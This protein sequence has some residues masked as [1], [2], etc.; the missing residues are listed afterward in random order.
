MTSDRKNLILE[1]LQELGFRPDLDPDGDI[2][3]RYEGSQ[4]YV[5][6]P[7][8]DTQFV[9]VYELWSEDFGDTR[10]DALELANELN[11]RYKVI[12]LH[13]SGYGL[14]VTCENFSP[15]AEGFV[16]VLL[17]SIQIVR[18]GSN[19]FFSRYRQLAPKPVATA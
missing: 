11:G 19:D 3:F 1:A 6:V 15:S 2:R 16:P 13:L 5:G 9:S 10:P 17:R 12:K 4:M 18:S 14:A 8:D 7:D